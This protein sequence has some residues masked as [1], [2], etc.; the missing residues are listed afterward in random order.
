MASSDLGW[1]SRSCDALVPGGAVKLDGMSAAVDVLGM[2]SVSDVCNGLVS[3][4]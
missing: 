2:A 1:L 3:R 4:L